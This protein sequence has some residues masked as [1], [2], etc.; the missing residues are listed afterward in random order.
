MPNRMILVAGIGLVVVLSIA[1]GVS[2]AEGPRLGDQFM[3]RAN[4]LP[5]VEARE[6][7]VDPLSLPFTVTNFSRD[8]LWVGKAWVRKAQVVPLSD[9]SSYYTD[10][11]RSNPK[12]A[13]A[14]LNRGIVRDSTGDS[15]GALSDFS[16][17]IRLDPKYA[18][19]YS[20]RGG[21][22]EDREDFDK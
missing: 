10:Y 3:P 2:V 19:T 1:A 8:W 21:V 20:L 18:A 13:W 4:C 12:S 14:Y 22:W 16:A 17:A 9:A 7:P 15:V 6:I 11:I 5:K